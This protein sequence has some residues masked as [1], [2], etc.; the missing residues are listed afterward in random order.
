M[1]CCFL[2]DKANPSVWVTEGWDIIITTAVLLGDPTCNE[3]AVATAGSVNWSGCQEWLYQLARA[4]SNT[5]IM[6]LLTHRGS[7]GGWQ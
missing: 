6:G 1:N 4:D 7:Q 5:Q 2:G 3:G